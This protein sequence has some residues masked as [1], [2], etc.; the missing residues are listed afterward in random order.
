MNLNELELNE[1]SPVYKSLPLP[2]CYDTYVAHL[3]QCQTEKKPTLY[4][5]RKQQ[6]WFGMWLSLVLAIGLFGTVVTYL[7]WTAS[8][9]N[10]PSIGCSC[11]KDPNDRTILKGL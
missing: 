11:V 10:C 1:G 4:V 7:I 2:K 6:S 3:R 5:K 9:P 8:K